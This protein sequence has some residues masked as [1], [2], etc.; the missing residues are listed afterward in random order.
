MVVGACPRV[1]KDVNTI[2]ART[3]CTAILC[4]QSHTCF[5]ALGIDHPK[6]RERGAEIGV[7][8]IH[9]PI[10]DF[11][12]ASQ[13][14]MIPEA[15]RVLNLLLK[16]GHK[17]YVHCTA[18]INRATL[19]VLSYLT[20]VEGHSLED[21]LELVKRKRPQAHPY[22]DCWRTARTRFLQGRSEEVSTRS[23]LIY[24]ARCYS[25]EAGTTGDDWYRAER[26]LIK[27]MF[28]NKWD[29]DRA[30]VQSW[31]ATNSSDLRQMEVLFGEERQ[32]C[33]MLA[34]K[35]Q[36][37]AF[38]QSEL[39][40][41]R[42]EVNTLKEELISVSHKLKALQQKERELHELKAA[43]KE[44]KDQVKTLSKEI[45]PLKKNLDD[46]WTE[47]QRKKELEA[48]MKNANQQMKAMRSAFEVL[49]TNLNR[50]CDIL[51]QRS[52]D[53]L[54]RKFGESHTV[55]GTGNDD[56]PQEEE[57]MGIESVQPIEL[58]VL[59]KKQNGNGHSP[60]SNGNGNG[61]GASHSS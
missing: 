4:L 24:E 56:A 3:G 47:L 45:H 28:E 22:L 51:Q 11:D 7:K 19:T 10:R 33:Q 30:V 37:T 34:S 8:V 27:D 31:N 16:T 59:P 32:K 20:F 9:V 12:H 40:A 52:E 46:A 60:H 54:N 15:V 57:G 36:S 44:E 55:P 1:P 35:V 48:E 43:L 38:L 39:D 41:T 23:Q 6:I 13:A 25:C 42:M 29:C 5:E 53:E 17:C 58:K 2:S 49:H 26:D 14:E 21:A 18:G 50:S 61:N